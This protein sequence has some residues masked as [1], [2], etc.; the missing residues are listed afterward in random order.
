MWNKIYKIIHILFKY[1]TKLITKFK[2]LL[3]LE[4]RLSSTRFRLIKSKSRTIISNISFGP[5]ILWIGKYSQDYLNGS[6]LQSRRMVK[7]TMKEFISEINI[8][9]GTPALCISQLEVSVKS[10][11]S[12]CLGLKRVAR[13]WQHFSPFVASRSLISGLFTS[14]LPWGYWL[15][16]P[17]V[18]V[19]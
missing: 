4:L 11:C 16:M 2:L 13:F 6:Y 18:F 8:L 17:S 12:L 5:Q 19:C 15:T 7:A 14:N 10:Q 1:T 9:E 3:T